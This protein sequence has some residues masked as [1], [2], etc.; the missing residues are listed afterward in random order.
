MRSLKIAYSPAIRQ[1][2]ST[3]RNLVE[4]QD[5]DYTDIAAAV[6]SNK[7]RDIIRGYLRDSV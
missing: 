3:K 7:D 1:Y 4:V 5:T 6:V 2:F